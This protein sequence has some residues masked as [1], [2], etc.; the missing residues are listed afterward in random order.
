[1]N[2]WGSRLQILFSENWNSIGKH[3]RISQGTLSQ[4]KKRIGI[5]VLQ[6]INFT[7]KDNNGILIIDTF[8]QEDNWAYKEN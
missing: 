2:I 3:T 6:A 4:T 7:S 1:M 8:I 5:Q